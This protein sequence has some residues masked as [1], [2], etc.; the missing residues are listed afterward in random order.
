MRAMRA[1]TAIR[2]CTSADAQI[3][4]VRQRA[5]AGALG[6]DLGHDD[7]VALVK[8][9]LE[10][11]LQL[12]GGVGAVQRPL[13]GEHRA[14]FEGAQAGAGTGVIALMNQIADDEIKLQ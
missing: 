10:D 3:G 4:E 9:F 8:K 2:A 12:S 6:P 1:D 14:G 13:V 5:A 11:I 7:A